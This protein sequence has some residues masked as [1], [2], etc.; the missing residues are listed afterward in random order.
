MIAHANVVSVFSLVISNTTNQTIKLHASDHCGGSES[1]NITGITIAP[2]QPYSAVIKV[3]I[4]CAQTI[5]GGDQSYTII[6]LQDM[7]GN[8]L[9]GYRYLANTY[10][11]TAGIAN[12]NVWEDYWPTDSNNSQSSYR[13]IPDDPTN[14]EC[15]LSP[16]PCSYRTLTFTLK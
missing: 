16:F 12:E 2:H 3:D 4:S 14:K 11:N 13:A 10:V 7:S 8:T 9:G 1:Q 6:D 15:Y 5:S